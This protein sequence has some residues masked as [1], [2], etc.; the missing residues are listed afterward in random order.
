MIKNISLFLLAFLMLACSSK[1]EYTLKWK[2]EPGQRIVYKTRMNWDIINA[3][4]TSTTHQNLNNLPTKQSLNS[5]HYYTYI[6]AGA[7]DNKIKVIGLD[8]Q[9]FYKKDNLFSALDDVD[10]LTVAQGKLLKNGVLINSDNKILLN[11]LFEMPLLK[12]KVGQT[13]PLNAQLVHTTDSAHQTINNVT[14][15][16]VEKH[17]QKQY[18]ILQYELKSPKNQKYSDDGSVHFKGIGV[19]NI[20]D[21]RWHKF[22][23]ILIQEFET[24]IHFKQVRKI[25]LEPQIKTIYFSKNKE[26]YQQTE[27]TNIDPQTETTETTETTTITPDCQTY[28]GVQI[29]ASANKLDLDATKFDKIRP[30][31]L[32]EKHIAHE[33]KYP[34]KYIVG[35]KC[36]RN[37]AV[38]LQAKVRK[39]GFENAF[40]VEI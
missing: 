39:A 18:A 5:H 25:R 9:N 14:F 21:G 32:F 19:F 36:S 23:G 35:K 29:M 34:Y 12:V 22:D 33:K 28:Y 17:N 26:D 6:Q 15:K 7:E 13:W 31:G 10:N 11:I 2:L 20:T 24:I 30:F 3:D 37:E 1:K 27:Q 16:K 38:Q 4:D 8:P 40:V